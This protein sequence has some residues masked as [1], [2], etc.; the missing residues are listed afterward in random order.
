M[1]IWSMFKNPEYKN[2][3]DDYTENLMGKHLTG[4]DDIWKSFY[5]SE[6]RNLYEYRKKIPERYAMGDALGIAYRVLRH[7][8]EGELKQWIKN[9]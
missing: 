1:Q 4:R 8:E 5:F 3:R 9:N 7:K 6:Y 2:F